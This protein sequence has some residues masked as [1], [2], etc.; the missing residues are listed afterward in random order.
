MADIAVM[1]AKDED[2][3]RGLAD[4]RGVRLLGGTM[5]RFGTLSSD[6]TLNTVAISVLE[7]G[8]VALGEIE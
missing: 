4:A 5:H 7:S 1:V 3:L 2:E 8:V 6:T